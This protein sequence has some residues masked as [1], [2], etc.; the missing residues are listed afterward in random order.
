MTPAM[1]DVPA[2][3]SAR[4]GDA[5][6][7]ARREKLRKIVELGID[8][9]GGRFDDYQPIGEI[10]GRESEIVA[11]PPQPGERHGEQQGPRVRA[12]GRIVL[13]RD[14]GKLIFAD[15]RDWSGQ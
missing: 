10:R 1:T 13:M 14:T 11:H 6:E 4:S 15:I 12:A 3:N 2:E 7:A 8:P 5:L 9:W